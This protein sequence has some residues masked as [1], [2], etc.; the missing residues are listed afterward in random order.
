MELIL[1]RKPKFGSVRGVKEATAQPVVSTGRNDSAARFG[2]PLILP[3]CPHQTPVG[4]AFNSVVTA[5]VREHPLWEKELRAPVSNRTLRK[6]ARQFGSLGGGNHFLEIQRD[7]EERLWVMLHSGSRYLGVEVRDWYV[8]QGATQAGI[9]KRL[10]ARI[11]HLIAASS[12][13]TDY[14]SDMKLVMNFARE[15]RRE[16]ML[17]ALEVIRNHADQFDVASVEQQVI[18]IQLPSPG[19]LAAH[20]GLGLEGK[21]GGGALVKRFT[22]APHHLQWPPQQTQ[23]LV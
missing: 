21:T 4:S 20:L 22:L 9:D 16:M 14:L 17:R 1:A 11:P 23:N 12:L 5:R 8:E 15:S 7:H 2:M 6:L 13:A 18:D 19:P 3:C 10:Y